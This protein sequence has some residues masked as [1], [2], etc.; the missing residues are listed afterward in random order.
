ML[1][2]EGMKLDIKKFV[3]ECDTCQR[4]KYESVSL[5]GLLQLLPI[6][7]KVWEDVS[8]DFIEGL[9]KT[10]N[11]NTILM[12][13]KRMTKYNHFLTLKHPFTVAEVT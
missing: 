3:A 13:V 5:A 6:P 1:F 12:V 9:P 2:W 11:V 8:M 10:A 7:T 4:V